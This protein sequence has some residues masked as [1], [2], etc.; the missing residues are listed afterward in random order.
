MANIPRSL[1]LITND[2][3][4]FSI[5]PADRTEENF[6]PT[7]EAVRDACAEANRKNKIVKLKMNS[8]RAAF[9]GWGPRFI[10]GICNYGVH[11]LKFLDEDAYN[12]IIPQ[13]FFKIPKEYLDCFNPEFLEWCDESISVDAW[14][15][16]LRTLDPN[17]FENLHLGTNGSR[18][19]LFCIYNGIMHRVIYHEKATVTTK[20]YE[21][22]TYG[23]ERRP[24]S[25]Y[26]I[27]II[28]I[29]EFEKKD[30]ECLWDKS[31]IS[32]DGVIHTRLEKASQ[33]L[34]DSVNNQDYIYYVPTNIGN[35]VSGYGELTSGDLVKYVK[36]N[37]MRVGKENCYRRI[38]YYDEIEI[39]KDKLWNYSGGHYKIAA[40][41]TGTNLRIFESPSKYI[42][43]TAEEL[44]EN[45]FLDCFFFPMIYCIN[46]KEY[47]EEARQNGGTVRLWDGSELVIPKLKQHRRQT[48]MPAA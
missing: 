25:I 43:T 7:F 35:K 12:W 4:P 26:F 16:F 6:W 13:D 28:E 14:S 39:V 42:T 37:A 8:P 17:T 11:N 48:S 21:R 32:L 27:D 38:A 18:N 31:T 45:N 15:C 9:F 22:R 20:D 44:N 34:D 19:S 23:K 36:Y 2:A 40:L 47:E 29:E 30:E 5:D 3:E 33:I 46:P 1:L 41:I 10:K 24:F